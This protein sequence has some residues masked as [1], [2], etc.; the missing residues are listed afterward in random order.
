MSTLPDKRFPFSVDSLSAMIFN[1]SVIF[2]F[3]FPCWL[4]VLLGALIF[5]QHF[6]ILASSWVYLIIIL[7]FCTLFSILSIFLNFIPLFLY[8]FR[9]RF[10]WVYWIYSSVSLY[11][12]LHHLSLSWVCPIIFLY[13][14]LHCFLFFTI[15]LSVFSSIPLSPSTLY[16]LRFFVCSILSLFPSTL[17]NSHGREGNLNYD[18]FLR[19]ER[20][21]SE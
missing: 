14:L 18:L 3:I 17:Q 7:C 15:L 13:Y 20:P 21:D 6:P 9:L 16:P 1:I 5:F 12:I 2:F 11:V 19:S 4:V 8:S 10:S